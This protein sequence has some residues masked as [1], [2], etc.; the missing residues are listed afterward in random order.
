MTDLND[1]PND[2]KEKVIAAQKAYALATEIDKLLS[3]NFVITDLRVAATANQYV[4]ITGFVENEIEKQKVQVFLI[5]SDKV[6]ELENNLI[7]TN[8]NET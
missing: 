5:R 7:V 1:L 4:I 2:L 8:N 3:E 6:D